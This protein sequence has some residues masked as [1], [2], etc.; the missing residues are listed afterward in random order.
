[1]REREKEGEFFT[2]T[3]FNVH[4]YTVYA[5]FVHVDI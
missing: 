1:M 2:C 3:I 5:K 4:V